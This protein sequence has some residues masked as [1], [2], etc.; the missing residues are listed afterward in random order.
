MN[1]DD[2]K[3]LDEETRKDV[4]E[5]LKVTRKKDGTKAYAIAQFEIQDYRMANKQYDLSIKTLQKIKE[6]DDKE[7]SQ[8]KIKL[9]WLGQTS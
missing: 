7:Y 1:T 6:S 9:L 2:M 8:L 5:L 3:G 4:E